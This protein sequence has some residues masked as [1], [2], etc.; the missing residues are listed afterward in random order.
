MQPIRETLY[1]FVRLSVRRGVKGNCLKGDTHIE[2]ENVTR[3]NAGAFPYQQ[4]DHSPMGIP[5]SREYCSD[6]L[7]CCNARCVTL[8]G[9]LRVPYRS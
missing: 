5:V 4:I 1:E 3:A 8:D 7:Q 9:K 2:M 6:F